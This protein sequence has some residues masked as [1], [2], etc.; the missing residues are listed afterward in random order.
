MED[1]Y[2][3]YVL[4]EISGSN[5]SHDDEKLQNFLEKLLTNEIVTNGVV[6]QDDTQITSLWSL[7]E[8]I[9]EACSKAGAV[10][11]YDIS[12]PVPVLYQ[13]VKDIRI[14]LQSAGVLGEDKLVSDVIGYGHIG[15]GNLHLNIVAKSY[16]PKV[17][18]LIEPYVYEW[19]EQHK[20][21]ISAEHGL[22]L[23]KA[24]YL[25]YT[26]SPPMISL[27]KQIKQ[28]IDPNGIMNPYKFLPT[29]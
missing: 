2:P 12:M 9:P 19:T 27:M 22:G 14:R 23:M 1:N 8:G 20:G 7:R 24:D 29:Q 3:F 6:A 21:S 16:D 4:V 25:G 13:M 17:T 26:K 10:Y 5:K 11:K 18:N 28:S 15:D